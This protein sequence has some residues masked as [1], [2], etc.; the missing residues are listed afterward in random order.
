MFLAKKS[1]CPQ[2]SQRFPMFLAKKTLCDI[3]H[4]K[5]GKSLTFLGQSMTKKI[6]NL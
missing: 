6:G 1:L 2:K 4:K 3:F 5:D